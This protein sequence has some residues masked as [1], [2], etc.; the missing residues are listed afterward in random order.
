MKIAVLGASG[1]AGRAV[2]ERA[3]QQGILVHALVRSPDKLAAA[4]GLTAFVGEALKEAD[5]RRAIHDVDV[6]VT[7][8]RM[9][10]GSPQAVCSEAAKVL[11]RA[12]SDVGPSRLIAVSAHGAGDTRRSFLV[13]VMRA[14]LAAE[15]RDK[16]VMEDVIAASGLD[17]TILRPGPLTNRP[18]T[19]SYQA[20]P[21]QAI[22][23]RSRIARQDL[24]RCIV[25]L[26]SR[27]APTPRTVTVTG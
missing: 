3:L 15:M 16:D 24:A 11:V 2:V 26:A 7:A 9:S 13:R 25:D 4:Q 20:G 5:V 17:W 21:D 10:R 18:G 23:W 14:L 22:S 1:A 12:M 6:V 27:P 19:G 8:L